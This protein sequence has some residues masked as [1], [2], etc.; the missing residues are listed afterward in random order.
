MTGSLLLTGTTAGATVQ[1]P[2]LR[3]NYNGKTAKRPSGGTAGTIGSSTN[4][5]TRFAILLPGVP[6]VAQRGIY[7]SHGT[8]RYGYPCPRDGVTGIYHGMYQTPI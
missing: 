7:P 8:V 4:N 2:Y 6:R 1:Y 5:H 3:G